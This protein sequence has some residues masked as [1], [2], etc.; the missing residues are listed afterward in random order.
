MMAPAP[1][2]SRAA[3]RRAAVALTL[4]CAWT[5][6]CRSA[7]HTAEATGTEWS[8]TALDASAPAVAAAGTTTTLALAFVK[9]TL[10][11]GLT[12]ILHEDHRLP[13]VVLNLMVKVGSRFEEPGHTGFAHLFEHLMF[14]GT[15]RVPPKMYDAWMEAEGGFNNAW[16]AE[17]RT[18]YYDVGPSHTLPLLLW[19]EADRFAALGTS[20]TAA[21]LEAQREIVRNERRQ[22]SENRPYGQA[23]LRLPELL[24]P[25]GHPYH[26]PVIGSH[27]DLQAAGVADVVAFFDRWYVP[28]N[29]VLVLVGDFDANAAR[30]LIERS[31]ATLPRGRNVPAPSAEPTTTPRLAAEVRETLRDEVQLAKVIMA[32]HSPPRFAPGEAELALLAAVLEQG[33]TSRL[34]QALVYLRPLAQD[35]GATQSSNEL[36]STFTIEAI[37]QPGVPLAKLEDAIDRELQRL[38]TAGV[39][40][41]ELERARNQVETAFVTHLESRQAQ[42][43]AF[44]EYETARGEPDFAGQDLARF[45]SVTRASLQHY[46][47]LLTP[48]AR[49]V[50]RVVPNKTDRDRAADAPTQPSRAKGEPR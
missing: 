9:Y 7:S 44:A 21:K 10:A 11:N 48:S 49:V 42:A 6:A 12:V 1:R 30:E 34:Y 39:T 43:A 28:N 4:A 45:R 47:G 14:M 41:E 15:E 5:V 25:E 3:A 31:F 40:Q 50:L 20:M 18:N 36:C 37:A 29:V 24:Y 2:D 23:E 33:T 22:T 27:A 19:L 35:V 38:R 46:A 26:H 8:T 32:W 16:T 17:D 13:E